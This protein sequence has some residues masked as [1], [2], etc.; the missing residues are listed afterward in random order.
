MSCLFADGEDGFPGS[1]MLRLTYSLSEAN[2]L[3]LSYEAM[4]LDKP[5]VASFTTHAF[6]NL[7][8][9]S[10]D[11]RMGDVLDHELTIYA[12]RYFATSAQL[13]ATGGVLPVTGTALD[14]CEPALLGQ[15]LH[16]E[17]SVLASNAVVQGYDHCYLLKPSAVH[18]VS[19]AARVRSCSSGLV[20]E[21]WSTEP[22]MQLY[23]GLQAGE[24]LAG[25]PGKTGHAYLQQQSLCLE[26]QGY[27]N[28]PN[29][30][31]F[32]SSVHRPG[33]SRGGKT[34]YRFSTR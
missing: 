7:N 32:P 33:E 18:G 9:P 12:D 10:A 29:C 22:A 20:M 27:P 4:A 14:F 8:G 2:E 26:P 1:L 15:R 23:T 5:T 3:V 30:A 17:D 11:G 24:P 6:F 19:L 25:G 34:L 28:A 16:R 21:V 13:V 31:A